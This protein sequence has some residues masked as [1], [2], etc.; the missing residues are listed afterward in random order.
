M[1][2]AYDIA[3]NLTQI[4]YPDGKTV[5]YSYDALNRL[6]NI[7]I[8]W[9]NTSATPSYD[10][11]GR[12]THIAHFNASTTTYAYDNADRLTD[13]NHSTGSGQT[14]VDYHFSLDANGNRTQAIIDNE[15]ILPTGLVDGTQSHS[16]NPER[17]RLLS[18]SGAS[19]HNYSY[20]NEGQTE[21]VSG[22]SNVDYHFDSAHR[23]VAYNKGG[24]TSHYHYD[25]IGNRLR[26][27]RNGSTTQYLYGAG[28]NL[29]AEADSSGTI[30][31]YYIHGLGLMAFVDAQS[32]Q[33]YVYHHDATG[34]TVAITDANQNIVNK[35]AY[36]AYGKILA[37]Q[38]Q[39]SQPFTY[40]GQ[41][42]VM[43]E[44]DNLYYMRA[45][46]YDAELGRFISEDPIGFAGGINAYAYVGGNPIGAVDP[47]G[48]IEWTGTATTLSAVDAVG[49]TLTRYTLT[50]QRMN[51]E[52]ATVKITAVGGSLGLGVV[53]GGT[54]SNVVFQ[55]AL[56]F[57]NPGVFNG[58]YEAIQAGVTVPFGP[59]YGASA[60]NMGS[61]GSIGH[62]R[63][64][65]GY[66]ASISATKGSSTVTDII[67]NR[68]N[69]TNLINTGK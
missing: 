33:L 11:A 46:Y 64:D 3:S 7:N 58:N 38:E 47:S 26:A 45:R 53:V 41:Y 18:S 22:D 16:Y 44:A 55:D 61:A 49:A 57:I 6:S 56:N 48:L 68:D 35:Y 29:L 31:R 10:A 15:A 12:L 60:V 62:G 37:K 65:L 4:T 20:D 30:T 28:G 27:T 42:G 59:G 63:I 50:S 14:L 17:N 36:S 67:W 8:D 23:L 21:N 39:I 51:G 66:E 43:T 1:Q 34:H 69:S 19:T 13:L 9:L 40:V 54:R 2:Y 25:G 32:N 52:T 24:Q 5:A